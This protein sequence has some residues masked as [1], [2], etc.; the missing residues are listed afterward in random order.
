[1]LD[2]NLARSRVFY[3]LFRFLSLREPYRSSFS[4]IT[5][6]AAPTLV[7]A[8]IR[9][10]GIGHGTAREKREQIERLRQI[11]DG[12]RF[13]IVATGIGEGFL[14]FQLGVIPTKILSEQKPQHGSKWQF[15]KNLL[16]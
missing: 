10:S 16:G 2:C 5:V 13:V 7:A 8:R 11:P 9:T 1:M 12:E 14:I 3:I 15:D 4:R 6:S